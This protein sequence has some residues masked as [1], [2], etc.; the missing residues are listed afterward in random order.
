MAD[1]SQDFFPDTPLVS[2]GIP[3]YNRPD[4]LRQTLGYI[5]GQS[6]RNLEIIVSDN[7]SP[8]PQTE[9]VVREFMKKDTRI[10]YF[11]QAE[12]KGATFNFQFVLEKATGKYFMWAAD[13]DQW[14]PEF[15]G[16][17]M[18]ELLKNPNCVTAFC[19]FVFLDTR[20][21]PIS[22]QI[23]FNYASRHRIVRLIKLC[24]YHNDVCFYGIHRT[25]I[26]K[27]TEVPVWLGIN[28]KSP[29]NTAYPRLFYLF[30]SGDFVMAGSSNLFF[31]RLSTEAGR[32]EHYVP[33]VMN[34]RNP[35]LAYFSFILLKLNAVYECER[36]IWKS[37]RSKLTV[38]FCIGPLL[39]EA[40][41]DC[42]NI[43]TKINFFFRGKRPEKI[44][45]VRVLFRWYS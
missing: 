26:L 4:G 27:E 45:R 44:T 6:Y 38:I 5:T 22:E 14:D 9:A 39:A 13:D 7:C 28:A 30:S 36:S 37:S 31:K 23:F 43:P 18:R 25:D 15:I 21:K 16:C 19:P 2:V 12:N 34:N 29:I 11:R 8:E 24:L 3:I 32:K 42:L 1:N 33:F 20:G 10:H 40:V 41:Y 35:V 17:L